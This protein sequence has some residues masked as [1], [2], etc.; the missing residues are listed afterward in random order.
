MEITKIPKTLKPDVEKAK[1][2]LQDA[3]L[4]RYVAYIPQAD[5]DALRLYAL[6]NRMSGSELLR[7][8]IDAYLS[9]LEQAGEL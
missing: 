5:A 6:K 3:E 8:I 2:A 9:K 7:I 1:A 4:V